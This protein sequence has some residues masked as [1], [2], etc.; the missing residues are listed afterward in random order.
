MSSTHPLK[1]KPLSYGDV[2]RCLNELETDLKDAC[3]NLAQSTV[4]L[5]QGFDS[6]A[7]QLHSVDLQALMPPV[8]PQ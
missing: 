3:K 6:I 4:Q 5:A 8:K 7:V 1:R 2:V